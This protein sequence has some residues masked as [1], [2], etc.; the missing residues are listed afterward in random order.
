VGTCVRT[1]STPSQEHA[2][3]F[4]KQMRP[5]HE[6][7]R[8]NSSSTFSFPPLSTLGSGRIVVIETKRR[9]EMDLDKYSLILTAFWAEEDAYNLW[10]GNL[11]VRL[12]IFFS[13][14]V[15]RGFS[16]FARC[17]FLFFPPCFPLLTLFYPQVEHVY[18]F[19]LLHRV[20]STLFVNVVHFRRPSKLSSMQSQASL[21][22]LSLAQ[23]SGLADEVGGDEM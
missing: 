22:P 15:H 4:R 12:F 21:Y 1:P 13:Q 9:P 6:F 17:A 19:D 20:S 11:K 18:F 23:R 8:G 5:V 10:N 7:F 2:D 3:L 14:I 16:F